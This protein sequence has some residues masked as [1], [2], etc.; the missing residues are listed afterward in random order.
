MRY[1]VMNS[2]TAYPKDFV[3]STGAVSDQAG[4][5][6]LVNDPEATLCLI[7]AISITP[8]FING[9]PIEQPLSPVSRS[10]TA[11]HLEERPLPEGKGLLRDA[12]ARLQV[13]NKGPTFT[14]RLVEFRDEEGRLYRFSDESLGFIGGRGG[15][16]IPASLENRIVFQVAQT[17]SSPGHLVPVTS[18][19]RCGTSS[20]SP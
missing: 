5:V 17:A 7:E 4:A 16:D 10:A 2:Q 14:V 15:G 12:A 1:Q 18:P 11:A 13:P 20:I 3:L 8:T 9:S 6:E 19:R